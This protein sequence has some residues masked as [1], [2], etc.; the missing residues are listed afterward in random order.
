[1]AKSIVFFD[2]EV[3][4]DDKKIHDIGAVHADKGIYH[5]SSVRDFCAFLSDVEYICGHNIIHHDMMF[6]EEAIE[7]KLSVK[8]IDTLYLSPLLFPKRPYHRLLKNDKL[9]VEELN[10]P[11]NDSQKAKDLFYDEVNA[12][13]NL[14]IGRKKIFC[15]LLYGFE[16][17]QG[18]FDYVDFRPYKYNMK[19]MILDGLTKYS[20]AIIFKL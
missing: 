16:E 8:A 15:G 5:S 12:F 9:Q 1:M 7:R 14:A 6:L 20:G 17:F 2:T 13:F 11:V 3:S 18:F 4:V 19:Q 10:N